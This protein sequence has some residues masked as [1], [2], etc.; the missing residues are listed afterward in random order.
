VRAPGLDDADRR[1]LDALRGNARASLKEL[2]TR[3]G[4]RPTTVFNRIRKLSEAGV[5]ERFTIRVNPSAVGED[6]VVFVLVSG[7]N[8]RFAD[9]WLLRSKHV[10]EAYGVTGEY[11][12][13][14]K[15]RFA[16]KSEFNEFIL[17]FRERYKR[18]ITRTVSMIETVTL[19]RD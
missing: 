5:I 11:D 1:V 9:D 13:L 18:S 12:M 7:M 10:A 4:L 15:L 14:L 6:F 3:T 16:G 8:D 17:S 19:K 2:A